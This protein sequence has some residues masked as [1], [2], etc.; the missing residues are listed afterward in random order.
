MEWKDWEPIY[1]DIVRKLNLD[2]DADREATIILSQLLSGSDSQFLLKKL[3]DLIR[4]QDI[5]ICGAGPSLEQHIKHLKE[6]EIDRYVIVAADGASTALIEND[7]YCQVIVTDLDGDLNDI[8][9]HQ[10]RGAI[11]IVHAHGDN[12]DTIKKH[13]SQMLPV[14]GSTQVEPVENV[15]LWGGFTDGDRATHLVAEHSPG[16]VILAGMDFGTLVGRW[17]KPGNPDHYQAD[18]RKIIKL[19]IAQELLL[20]PLIEAKVKYSLLK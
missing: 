8:K 4:R 17:S 16:N 5:L 2:V 1:L 18:S 20:R 13:I 10:E 19:E 14:L 12:I 3:N 7:V 6:E 15:F 11:A 9:L